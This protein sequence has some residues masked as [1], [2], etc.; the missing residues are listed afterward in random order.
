MRKNFFE[1]FDLVYPNGVE[2]KGKIR[3]GGVDF[4]EPKTKIAG[5]SFSG[6]NLL[7]YI[8]R[9][10]EVELDNGFLNLKGIY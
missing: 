2:T 5:V 8:G 4:L 6:I 3:I 1:L 9:D 7:D 10:F